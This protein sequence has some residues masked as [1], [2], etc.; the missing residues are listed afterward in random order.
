MSLA[1]TLLPTA[2]WRPA[3]LQ[4]LILLALLLW[5]QW[6]AAAG[7]ASIWWRSDTFA[8]ALLVPPIVLWLIWRR[9]ADLAPLQPQPWWPGLLVL[10]AA[11]LVAVMGRLA[12]VNVLQHLAVVFSI[13][14]LALCLFG[15][16]VCKRIAFPLLFLLF[17]PPFGDFLVD[18]MMVHTADFTVGALRLLGIPVFREG[19]HFVIPSGNW[20]VVEACSGLRYLFASFM[21]GTLFAYLN[22][23]RWPGRLGFM[24]VSLLVPVVANWL[25]ALIIVLLGHY[26]SNR[27]AT[28]ADHLVYGWV[29]FGII[30]A[31]MFWIGA[32]W[33]DAANQGEPAKTDASAALAAPAP[34]AS[35]PLLGALV[36]LLVLPPQWAEQL[37]RAEPAAVAATSL[38]GLRPTGAWQP[39]AQQQEAWAPD[40]QGVALHRQT[41]WQQ[42]MEAGGPAVTLDVAVYPAQREGAKAVSS[43]NSLVRADDARWSRMGSEPAADGQGSLSRWLLRRGSAEQAIHLAQRLYWVDGEFT[44]SEREAKLLGLRQQIAGRGDLQAV[45]VLMTASTDD[46]AARIAR[47]WRDI[48]TPLNERLREAAQQAAGT[49][50]PAAE[51]NAL[52]R[53][54]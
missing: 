7:M 22:F 31:I 47:F 21:V 38:D 29:F 48:R 37:R 18:P 1:S 46:G 15:W 30:M 25:R 2:A 3:L 33:A 19:L 16:Q 6:E 9:R 53:T 4:G 8:H 12:E 28:G 32:R 40:F 17:A 41:H 49:M 45:I 39:T 36:L 34:G 51:S 54:Q 13:Q 27:I 5:S 24:L 35:W 43:V 44:T 14:A 42:A 11:V 26:S 10:L 20:S 52:V 23:Q 50:P